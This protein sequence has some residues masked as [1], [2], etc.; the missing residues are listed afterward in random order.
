MDKWPPF[1]QQSI[2]INIGEKSNNLVLQIQESKLV[3]KM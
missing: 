1:T 2:N 3:R